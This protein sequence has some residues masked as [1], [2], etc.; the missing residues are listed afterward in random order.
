VVPLE[1]ALQRKARQVI[2]TLPVAADLEGLCQSVYS[3][4][5]GHKGNCDVVL[6]CFTEKDVLVR[7]RP[8]STIR[9]EGTTELEGS[10]VNL[11]CQVTWKN[12]TL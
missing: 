1:E 3:V 8:H 5:D 12:A 7:V 9:V 4:L 11:G 10:L 2:V 6:E